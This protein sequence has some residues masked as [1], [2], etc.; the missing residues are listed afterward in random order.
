MISLK[1]TWH[2]PRSTRSRVYVTVRCPSV[3]LS[4]DGFAAARPAGRKY[5]SISAVSTERRAAA[6]VPHEHGPAAGN[7]G[8]AMLTAGQR[9]RN[10]GGARPAMLKPPGA[11]VSFRPRNIFPHFACCSLNLHSLSLC[12]LHTVK[13][14]HSVGTAGRI[15]RNKLT[16][17]T[18]PARI[19]RIE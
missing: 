3:C 11:R 16:K 13:T 1:I 5:R 12:C 18:S 19:S 9:R 14:S 7:A 10:G 8:G 6:A 17:H 4:Y 2:Y 15:L